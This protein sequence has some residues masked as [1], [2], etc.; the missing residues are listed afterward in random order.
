VI[1]ADKKQK[2]LLELKIG[3]VK[4]LYKNNLITTKQYHFLLVKYGYYC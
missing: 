1:D 2:L 4:Q 3:I